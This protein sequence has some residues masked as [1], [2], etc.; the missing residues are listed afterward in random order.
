MKNIHFI[1]IAFIAFNSFIT[2]LAE[3]A[4]YIISIKRIENV[5]NFDDESEDNQIKILELV[6]DRMNNIY[7]IIE[8]NIDSYRLEN[9]EIDERLNEITLNSLKKR[10]FNKPIKYIFENNNR[11]DYDLLKII[12]N[13][14]KRSIDSNVSDSNVEYFAIDS[15]LINHICPILN[16]YTIRAYLS[17][18]IV[19]EVS[20]LEN[21][22]GCVKASKI[23]NNN[24][25]DKT[26]WT[27]VSVQE[28]NYFDNKNYFSHLSL[29]SQSKYNK[30]KTGI[31][32]NNYYYPESAGQGIDIFFI[33]SGIDLSFTENYDTYE[34]TPY[35]RTITCD[36]FITDGKS[37]PRTGEDQKFCEI[38]T[39]E[40]SDL[41]HG[42]AVSSA[43]AGT[44][45][46]AAKKA[47]IHMIATDFYVYDILVALD[48]IK[49]NGVPHKTIINH[50]RG[51]WVEF[52]EVIQNKI[53]ELVDEGFIIFASVGNNSKDACVPDNNVGYVKLLSTYDNVI[54]VGATE[55]TIF[56]DIKNGYQLA[57]YSD[58]GNCID[59]FAPGQIIHPDRSSGFYV[60]EQQIQID[61]G[62]SYSSALTAGVA[63]TIMSE[64]SEIKFTYETM[65]QMLIDFSLKDVLTGIPNLDTPNRIL[66]NGKHLVFSPLNQYNG[67]GSDSPVKNCVMGCCS[68]DGTCI[69]PLNDINNL[70]YIENG[71][72]EEY[73]K[74]QSEIST[75]KTI[76]TMTT[77]GSNSIPIITT[78]KVPPSSSKI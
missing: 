65:L 6:N 67:C 36:T 70:C 77:L 48:Y 75:N 26:K 3:N 45:Y 27:G 38:F 60:N 42:I 33:D 32:D 11:P 14:Q 15:K 31:Y 71:C 24:V 69:D 53:N 40:G 4:F 13:N 78:T 16:Y 25:I 76:P 59:I 55:S 57:S 37:N 47:N 61:R 2:A 18:S 29:I 50:S 46:G 49:L 51:G 7:D 35:K 20:N 73:G 43:A 12:N 19:E 62:T 68:K 28:Q 74:C 58:Y 34:G 10:Q 30:D 21:I 5:K 64:H 72:Q 41:Y 9:D 23:E 52:S 54:V 22:E 63:A 1:F 8:N 17:D 39:D 44:L 56:K 66:N